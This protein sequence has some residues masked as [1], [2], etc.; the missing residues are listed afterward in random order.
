MVN[1]ISEAYPE[2]QEIFDHFQKTE[3]L[4]LFHQFIY[5][6]EKLL[7]SD[8]RCIS[9]CT[10]SPPLNNLIWSW[11]ND[12]FLKLIL[13]TPINF[14]SRER[15][16]W[17]NESLNVLQ[18]ACE[19]GRFSYFKLILEDIHCKGY[20][21]NEQGAAHLLHELIDHMKSGDYCALMEAHGDP[22]DPDPTDYWTCDALLSM[23]YVLDHAKR[24]KIDLSYKNENG[25][26]PF[27]RIVK[28]HLGYVDQFRVIE[29]W[30]NSPYFQADPYVF[31][32][33]R[34]LK[35]AR[36]LVRKKFYQCWKNG[37]LEYLEI[38]YR[39]AKPVCERT[40]KKICMCKKFRWVN[41]HYHTLNCHKRGVYDFS[42]FSKEELGHILYQVYEI[43]R[44]SKTDP[45][46]YV[47][48]RFAC[49]EDSQGDHGLI[50]W[51][52]A[53]PDDDS[54]QSDDTFEENNENEE[55]SEQ[56]NDSDW[57]TFSEEDDSD[58]ESS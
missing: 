51:S 5:G 31:T 11:R 30:M 40:Q 25:H 14:S 19:H 3:G 54:E 53:F 2:W 33:L 8:D 45:E 12:S 56:D 44:S 1:L 18:I 42:G 48:D 23:R 55:S 52:D 15:Y 6:L 13:R 58:S 9:R 36:S 24:L 37:S 57:S 27:E 46:S 50:K 32:Q 22:Y 29:M 34:N 41:M 39:I 35:S 7:K 49:L 21:I 4:P 38:S 43:E 28:E 26:T 17:G 20:D 10:G 47:Y 16:S